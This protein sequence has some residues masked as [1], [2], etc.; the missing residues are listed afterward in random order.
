MIWLI[1]WRNVWRN[2]L[3]SIIVIL[4]I[5]LGLFGTLF[6]LALSNG[7]VEQK[8]N[9]SISNEISHIQIHDPEFIQDKS[10]LYSFGN[11]EEMIGDIS[12]IEGVKAACGRLT[13]SGMAST[14]T[15]GTG[16]VLM[17]IEPAQEKEVT[18]IYKTLIEGNYFEET[19]RTPQIIIGK[20]LATKLKARTG[21]KIVITIQDVHGDL[22]YGLFK[23][24]GIYK[25]SNGMYDEINVFVLKD[26]FASLLDFDN[27][28]ATEIA[29]R[30]M[31][32]E[33]T[34]QV[35][36]L[37]KQK[38]TNLSVMSWKEIDPIMLA[39]SSMTDQFSYLLLVI[40]LIAMAFGIINTML[41]S[42]MERI[43][44]LGML[45]AIG[46]NKRK[47]FLMIMLETLMLSVTG[48]VIGVAL[49][50]GTISWTGI[51]GLNFAKWAEGFEAWG[52]SALIYPS[53]YGQIYL[54][55]GILVFI[56]AILSSVY[57]AR[58]ALR[59]KPAEAIRAET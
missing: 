44:E 38:Y 20:K 37:L 48:A 13:S 53:L 46:M 26:D 33:Q 49:S 16:V 4:A 43:R 52:Y 25:T 32:S 55:L 51:S 31:D 2:K 1:S 28:R 45:M 39:L 35:T 30:L 15:T 10:A 7:M 56:T 5:S 47:V 41:M 40:I 14:A 42:I 50:V 3:R 8:I 18:D 24:A 54:I 23:V 58:K 27:S 36:A 17:G 34:D 6:M 57:P 12:R 29:V 59:F 9:A 22:V 11:A 21:S 19:T